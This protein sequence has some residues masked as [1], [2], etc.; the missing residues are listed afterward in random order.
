MEIINI[1]LPVFL[2]IGLG[3]L[4]RAVGFLGEAANDVLSR[5]VFYVAAPALLFHGTS[6]TPL[7][8]SVNIPVLLLIAAVTLVI[9][10][11]VYFACAGTSPARRGVLAQ[12]SHRS[13]M[14]F[15]GLPIITNAYGDSVLGPAA[16]MIGFL[17]VWYNFLA[18]LFLTLPHQR[19]SARSPKV[20]LN[21]ATKMLL[22]PLIIGCVSGMLVSAVGLKLPMSLIRALDLVGKTALP[23]ALISVGGG[24]EFARLRA[25]MAAALTISAVK[26]IVYPAFVYAGLLLMHL[27]GIDLEVPVLLMA[28]PAAVVSYIMAKE[29][30]GD[31]RLAGAIVI[32]STSASILTISAWLFFFRLA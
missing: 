4:L 5:L 20:W 9:G 13:N 29:M 24:L 6:Q 8:R 10:F 7:H 28:T 25:E 27:S 11:A 16:V 23:L 3:F 32:G 30:E 26:L 1:I 12:G 15:V 21:S 18:V 22:N 2:I 14:V 19:T 17:V 31:E